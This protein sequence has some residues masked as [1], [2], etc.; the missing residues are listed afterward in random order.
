MWWSALKGAVYFPYISVYQRQAVSA[1]IDCGTLFWPQPSLLAPLMQMKHGCQYRPATCKGLHYGEPLQGGDLYGNAKVSDAG[2]TTNPYDSV[3]S[4]IS[5]ST[6]LNFWVHT[7][8]SGLHFVRSTGAVFH[9]PRLPQALPLSLV[10]FVAW[11][12]LLSWLYSRGPPLAREWL[13][14]AWAI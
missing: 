2:Y 10:H 4:R 3:S 6:C 5:R 14:Q 1:H 9:R 12:K 11:S 7:R 8:G 13:S